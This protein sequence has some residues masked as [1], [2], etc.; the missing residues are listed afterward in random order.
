MSFIRNEIFSM[1]YS[2]RNV[3]FIQ[4]NHRSCADEPSCQLCYSCVQIL[5]SV[6]AIAQVLPHLLQLRF[7][8][9]KIHWHK[10]RS[11]PNRFVSK[12]LLPFIIQ[13]I[14]SK[15]FALSSWSVCVFHWI[16][17]L[18]RVS[19]HRLTFST[20]KKIP[21]EYFQWANRVLHDKHAHIK[22]RSFWY[23]VY[24]QRDV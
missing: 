2:I 4:I 14:R 22:P 23:L 24:N 8:V 21:P 6:I 5:L 11:E 20:E 3:R 12:H 10:H 1:I 15:N 19:I 13:Y 7:I 9:G 16:R 17:R 18:L